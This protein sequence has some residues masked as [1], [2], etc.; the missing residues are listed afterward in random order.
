MEIY[1]TRHGE[2]DYNKE[3]RY[4]GSIDILLNDTGRKQAIDASKELGIKFDVVISSPLKRAVETAKILSG[5]DENDIVIDDRIKEIYMGIY[6]GKLYSEADEDFDKFFN[7]PEEYK[8]VNGSESFE[9]LKKRAGEFVDYLIKQYGNANSKMLV[10][11]H[12]A[13][14]HAMLVVINDLPMKDFWK[15]PVENCKVIKLTCDNEKLKMG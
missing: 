14:I 2:T 13:F 1:V 5:F 4:Q 11:S 7:K 15:I 3:K 12:G 10:V 9:S 8:S 6:E